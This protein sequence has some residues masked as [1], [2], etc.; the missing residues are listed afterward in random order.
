MKK[1]IKLLIGIIL[2]VLLIAFLFWIFLINSFKTSPLILSENNMCVK[3]S[4]CNYVAFTGGCYTQQYVDKVM[5]AC[6][7]KTGNCPAEAEAREG[8]IC[9]CENNYCATYG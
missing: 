9:K 1:K 3:D 5:F 8:V 6:E 2:A 4:D 7:D